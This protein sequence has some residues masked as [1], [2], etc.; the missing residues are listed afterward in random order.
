MSRYLKEVVL[1]SADCLQVIP[2]NSRILCIHKVGLELRMV[3][4][5][6]GDDGTTKSI[7][8]I[9]ADIGTYIRA[10]AVYINSLNFSASTTKHFFYIKSDIED[11]GGDGGTP[12]TPFEDDEPQEAVPVTLAGGM[13]EC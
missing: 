13:Q 3:I 6:W 7:N 1:P 5:I 4:E 9:C 2:T 11:R 8:L 12:D 10:E